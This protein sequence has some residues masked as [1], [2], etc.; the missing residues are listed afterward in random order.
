LPTPGRSSTGRHLCGA[1]LRSRADPGEREKLR[2]VDGA[3]GDQDLL[4][5]ARGV[6]AA[7]AHIFDAD[8]AAVLDENA[9]RLRRGADDE[10]GARRRGAQIGRGRAPVLA[11][12]LR[13]LEQTAT[14][15]YRAVEIRI[16]RNAGLLRRLE[17]DVAQDIGVGPLGDVERSV[18]AVELV[19]EALVALRLD[20]EWQHVGIAPAGIAELPPMVV[21]SGLTADI[22]HRIDR[23]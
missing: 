16:E 4:G 2:R 3:A 1:Q 14:R 13:D 12:L 11:V 23:A 19:V 15:L 5:G 20:E 21:V 8:R 17:K 7:A 9:R 10:V 6:P 22:D 18:A